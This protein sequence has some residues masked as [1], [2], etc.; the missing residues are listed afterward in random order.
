MEA[1]D[2]DSLVDAFESNLCAIQAREVD[3]ML[4]L[5]PNLRP[6]SLNPEAVGELSNNNAQRESQSEESSHIQSDL[7]KSPGAMP[8]STHQ[9]LIRGR[10]ISIDWSK[11]LDLQWTGTCTFKVLH[12]LYFFF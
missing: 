7:D 6:N 9:Q 5:F 8:A 4:H 12:S 10:L 11:A 1:N 3:K 2:P